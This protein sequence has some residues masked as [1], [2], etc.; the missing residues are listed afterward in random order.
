M[1]MTL[2][3]N[4]S[5]P[6]EAQADPPQADLLALFR[7][8]DHESCPHRY[9]FHLH[10]QASDGQLTPQDLVDQAIEIG[11]EDFAITDHHSVA[12]YHAAQ[13]YLVAQDQVS[14][15]RLWPGI[16][17]TAL[18]LNVEVHILGYGFDPDHL[19]LVDYTL[20]SAPEGEAAQAKNVIAALHQAGGLAVLAHPARY[21]LAL[22]TLIPAAAELGIDGVE[23]Y[24][25]Y[26]NPRPWTPSLEITEMVN[27]FAEHYNL[28]QT[29]G[30]DTHGTNILRR[31]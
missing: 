17:I 14:L 6:T 15:P 28:L 31:L 30:T 19:A 23:A 4:V 1:P 12:G 20:G 25:A 22:T 11:L 8:I 9:N 7:R 26:G 16:E 27:G 2:A 13:D 29:C 5:N 3:I 10:T 24:Y 21:K 18:L